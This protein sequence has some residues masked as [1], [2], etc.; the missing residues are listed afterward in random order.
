MD[1]ISRA[2]ERAQSEQRSV[3]SWVRP[4][5]IEPQL[6]NLELKPSTSVTLTESHLRA[7]HILCGHGKEDQSISDRYRLLRT[8]V[9]QALKLQGHN[10]LGITSPGAK[11]GKS[12]TSINL[13]ISI[14]REGSHK[15]VLVDADLR[16]P[17]I[18]DDLGIPAEKGLIDHLSGNVGFDEVLLRTSIEGLFV[19]PGRRE[20]SDIAVPELLSSDRM[21][22]LVKQYRGQEGCVVIIDLPPVHLGDD[23]VALAPYIDGILLIVREGGTSI[24]ALRE[25]V[26][27]LKDYT[28]LGT[29]LN[30]STER[31]PTFDGYYYRDT[32]ERA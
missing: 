7:R 25:S 26:E 13:A 22:E 29:V 19:V 32:K 21:R 23:V 9:L 12:L 31:R 11:D 27:L 6:D 15:V 20:E 17:S 1:H 18:A 30:Q 14:A 28:I 2:L 16:K 10:T 24:N 3:S 8:R 4:S 5:A